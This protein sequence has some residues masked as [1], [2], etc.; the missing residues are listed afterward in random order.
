MRRFFANL[1]ILIIVA[2]VVFFIGWIQFSVKPGTC[3]VLVSKTSGVLETPVLPGQFAW[4]WE[5]L[6]PTNANLLIFSMDAYKSSQEY[7]GALPSNSIYEKLLD[8][9]VDF[10][11]NIK[12]SIS[13]S[14]LPE[15]IVKYVKSNEIK[16]QE[17][18]NTLLE[19]K[20]MILAEEIAQYLLNSAK[21]KVITHPKALD[22]ETLK[23]MT[24]KNKDFSDI[25]LHSVEF[26]SVKIP[27]FEMYEN[28]KNLYETYK[29]DLQEIIKEKLSAPI[30]QHI[31]IQQEQ[32]QIQNIQEQ[33][34]S[35]SETGANDE[36]HE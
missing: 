2:C 33:N 9:N 34:E 26:E 31:Q 12:M 6:L 13:L 24:S 32:P 5:K 19:N 25:V 36:Q 4:R 17:D 14:M 3:G 29:N 22:S 28:S 16:T 27:D 18:L 30:V 8:N 20:A 15:E 23:L 7:S 10:S 1:F 35:S 21:D 11:Y